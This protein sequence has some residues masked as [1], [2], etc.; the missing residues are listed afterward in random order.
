MQNEKKCRIKAIYSH[1]EKM[2]KGSVLKWGYPDC[3]VEQEEEVCGFTNVS[4]SDY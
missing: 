3:A 2:N 4:G 1:S